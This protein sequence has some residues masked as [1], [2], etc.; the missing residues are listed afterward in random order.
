MAMKLLA[1]YNQPV[2][3]FSSDDQDNDFFSLGII[4]GTESTCPKLELGQ[5]IGTQT[6]DGFRGCR[7]LV[8]QSCLNSRF[9]KSLIACRLG[10]ELSVGIFR[11][12]D[13]EKHGINS[14][15]R[16]SRHDVPC[17]IAQDEATLLDK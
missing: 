2:S 3:D 16:T 5:R 8:L 15:V 7:G 14:C 13:P 9:Q 1:F 12:T 17:V 6:L 11:D 10:P 4:Q